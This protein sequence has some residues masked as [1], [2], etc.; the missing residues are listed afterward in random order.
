MGLANILENLN[1]LAPVELFKL[2]KYC[3]VVVNYLAIPRDVVVSV[4]TLCVR[5]V[6]S[7]CVK[8]GWAALLTGSYNCQ[9]HGPDIRV[10]P[11][12]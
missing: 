8:L 7:V 12:Y 10:S 4:P 6:Y 9:Y 3:C 5:K 2:I 11:L 1:H